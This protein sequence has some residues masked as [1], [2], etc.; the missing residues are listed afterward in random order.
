VVQVE[1]ARPL[2]MNERSFT[3]TTQFSSTQRNITRF[4]AALIEASP[5]FGAD[6]DARPV[7]AE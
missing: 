5:L 4:L 7:A 3:R 1:V 2:Y 6:P